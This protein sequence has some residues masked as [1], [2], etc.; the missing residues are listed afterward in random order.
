MSPSVLAQVPH[1]GSVGGVGGSLV[2]WRMPMSRPLSSRALSQHPS[3]SPLRA[4]GPVLMSHSSCLEKALFIEAQGLVPSRGPELT[5]AFAAA[6][7]VWGR[8]C[9]DG[10]AQTDLGS[11]IEVLVT[12]WV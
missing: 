5:V 1:P 11:T 8:V 3:S 7:W 2:L 4:W 9:S 12:L 6:F 10:M